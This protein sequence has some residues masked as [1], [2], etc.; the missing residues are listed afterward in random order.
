MASGMKKSI[1]FE[2]DGSVANNKIL[3]NN[4]F[5]FLIFDLLCYPLHASKTKKI[6]KAGH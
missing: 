3:W 4:L 5:S 6:D 2:P 1:T